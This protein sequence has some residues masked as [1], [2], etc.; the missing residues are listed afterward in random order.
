[1]E[2]EKVQ[3]EKKIVGSPSLLGRKYICRMEHECIT[4]HIQPDL[5]SNCSLKNTY[6]TTNKRNKK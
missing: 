1:M 2:D 5:A 4:L 6:S 3:D